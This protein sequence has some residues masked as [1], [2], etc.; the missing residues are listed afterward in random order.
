MDD[1]VNLLETYKE[2]LASLGYTVTGVSSSEEAFIVFCENPGRFDLVLTDHTMPMMTDVLLAEKLLD[3]RPDLPVILYSGY[4]EDV[5]PA[6]I[7]AKGIRQM[8]FKPLVKS[9]V[10]N[11]LHKYLS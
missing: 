7:K 11:I 3:I 9:E 1:E 8:I 4:A 6:M 5:T 2:L 10:A